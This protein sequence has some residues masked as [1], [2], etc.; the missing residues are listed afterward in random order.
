MADIILITKQ[1]CKNCEYVR[2]KVPEGLK[3]R[4]LDIESVEG[5]AEAAYYEIL[6]AHLPVLVV[7]DEPVRGT[8]NIKNK[9]AEL[10]SIR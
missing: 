9:M 2:S 10:A 3:V 8:I 6:D 4:I 1:R 7:D 5:T